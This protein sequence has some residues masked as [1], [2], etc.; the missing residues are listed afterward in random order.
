[1]IGPVLINHWWV[2]MSQGFNVKS[3]TRASSRTSPT[4]RTMDVSIIAL[5]GAGSGTDRNESARLSLRGASVT[6]QSG[7]T[8]QGPGIAPPRRSGGR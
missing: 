5:D 6:D 2:R 8:W 4:F 1:M 3:H 7:T